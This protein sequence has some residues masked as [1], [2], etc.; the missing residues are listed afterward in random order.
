MNY[1]NKYLKNN[2]INNIIYYENYSLN[3][4]YKKG[5]AFLLNSSDE[6]VPCLFED[7]KMENISQNQMEINFKFANINSSCINAFLYY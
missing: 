4:I 2:N 5:F 3:L 6:N 7:T 1:L